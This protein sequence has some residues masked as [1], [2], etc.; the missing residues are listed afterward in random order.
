MSC[1]TF[2]GSSSNNSLIFRVFD[3]P[4]LSGAVGLQLVPAVAVAAAA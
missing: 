3:L 4:V 2:V 1:L